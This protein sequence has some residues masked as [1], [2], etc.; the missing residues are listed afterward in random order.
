MACTTTTPR[1]LSCQSTLS[2]SSRD[3]R[4]L[5]GSV[6]GSR[7][8]PEKGFPLI[9]GR[10][11]SLETLVEIARRRKWL[12]VLPAIV[13][14]AAAAVIIQRLPNIYRSETLILVV[15]QRVPE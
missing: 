6:H 7:F 8:T 13:I 2:A 14:T 4:S 5:S 10:Q 12:I 9:P 11:Y 1:M 15:P 3:K